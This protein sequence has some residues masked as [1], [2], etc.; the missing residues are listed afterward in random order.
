MASAL[1]WTT[2]HD[3]FVYNELF[4]REVASN[5]IALRFENLA[6]SPWASD[7]RLEEL[8]AGHGVDVEAEDTMIFNV[9]AMVYDAEDPQGEQKII[10]HLSLHCTPVCTSSAPIETA[11]AGMKMFKESVRC[12]REKYKGKRLFLIIHG[13][14]EKRHRT[15]TTFLSKL[16]YTPATFKNMKYLAHIYNPL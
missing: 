11:L 2:K 14:D 16:N 15:Y 9:C 8:A 12:L 6:Y 10:K 5:T 7:G 3:I 1:N 13:E 4:Y